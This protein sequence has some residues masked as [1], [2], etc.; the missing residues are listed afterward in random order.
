METLALK[1]ESPH[2]TPVRRRPSTIN[3]RLQQG[4]LEKEWTAARCNRL[5]R[6]LT[7]RV[8]ILKKDISRLQSV[9]CAKSNAVE[10]SAGSRLKRGS[11]SPGDDDWAHPRKKVKKTYSARGG[12]TTTASRSASDGMQV[13]LKDGTRLRKGD[14]SVPMPILHQA[15]SE[16]LASQSST[17]ATANENFNGPEG[18]GRKRSKP[19]DG[20][21]L[22]QLS[23]TM[24]EI[25][26]STPPSRYTTY[27]GI[28]YGLEGLFRVTAAVEEEINPQ[29]P[30]S[31]LSMCL[32]AIPQY[33]TNE[34]MKQLERTGSKSAIDRRDVSTEIYDDLEA[35]GS[36]GHGWKHLKTVVRAHGTQVICT[37]IQEGLVDAD[38]CGI[39]VSLCINMRAEREAEMLL[40]ALLSAGVFT[41]PKSV[42][43]RFDDEIATRPLSIFWNFTTRRSCSSYRYR[44]LS[45]MIANGLLSISWLATKEFVTFWAEAVRE[46]SSN[47]ID[48]DAVAFFNTVLPLL[49]TYGSPGH[50]NNRVAEPTDA[51][52][53]EAVQQTFSS[54]IATLSAVVILSKETILHTERSTTSPSNYKEIAVLFRTCLAQWRLYESFNTKDTLFALAILIVESYDRD[55]PDIDLVA[56]LLNHLRHTDRS[57][58]QYTPRR[59]LDRFVCSLARCCGRGASNSGFEY[60][61]HSHVL[62]E[63]LVH[64]RE[65]DGGIILQEIIVDSAFA[66]ARQVPERAYL[67]YAAS[68]E[69]KFHVMRSESVDSSP[70]EDSD[71][72]PGYRWEE[73]IS[74][75]VVATPAARIEKSASFEEESSADGSECDTPFNRSGRRAQSKYQVRSALIT[76]LAPSS[77]LGYEN[78]YSDTSRSST[79]DDDSTGSDDYSDEINTATTYT[80]ST[81]GPGAHESD[82]SYADDELLITSLQGEDPETDELCMANSPSFASNTS[83]GFGKSRRHVG[84]AARLSQNVLRRSLHWQLFD[85]SDDELSCLSSLS[86]DS[87]PWR[88]S[89]NGRALT[90]KPQNL[91]RV[92]RTSKRQESTA[93]LE[94]SSCLSDSEDELGI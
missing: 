53:L 93:G 66:F 91:R 34:E 6:A 49:A 5:L 4:D 14:I 78:D 90:T 17:P 41:R 45:T 35:L 58:Q 10:S 60:L 13:S 7:S 38:F 88:Y 36:S 19:R 73:G 82:Q 70:S 67:D 80:E 65:S 25:R 85:E 16:P 31:L 57:T 56:L 29:G 55:S 21:A 62:L 63:T 92:K 69:A 9:A 12:R 11:A 2:F 15:T 64:S 54:L 84:R 28:Y 22:F 30:G 68:I 33:I 23:K 32:R 51:V 18:K 50:R 89:R 77:D 26:K 20:D 83:N 74:E 37:A 40:S 94:A 87:S 42:F 61:Q 46:F 59:D 75:W 86:R 27:E 24:R 72:R 3:N 43:T 1:S 48:P 52:L 71:S 47:S 39:L 81:E 76:E 44:Q 8:A 79:P